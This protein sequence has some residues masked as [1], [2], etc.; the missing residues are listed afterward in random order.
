MTT[1]TRRLS[2]AR[3]L[4]IYHRAR[5]L[6]PGTTQLISR[7]PTRAALGF[8]PIYAQSARGCRIT[9]V[10]GNEFIDW[11][12]AVGP[13]ILGYAH[14][15][16]DAAVK[17][18]IDRG[19]V[20]S[21]V[22]E[23]SVELAELLVRLV[24]SAEMVRYAKGGGEACTIAVRIAR[25]VTGRDKVLLCGYHGWHD[26]YLAANLGAERLADHLFNGIDPIGVPRALEGTALPFE[27]GDLD[28]LED[29]LRAHG[30]DVA[31]IIMEPMRCEMPPAGYL[32]GVRALAD[33]YGVVLIFDEVS[34]GWRIALGGV[35]QVTGVTPDLT[36]F[37]KA[38]SNGYP[39]AAVA[40]RRAVMEPVERMFISSAYW[41]DNIGIAASLATIRE[42]ERI[43]APALFE[44]LGTDFRERIDGLARETGCPAQ[45]VGVAA[46]PRIHFDVPHEQAPK[47]A[48][49]F[50]QE[51]ARRGV[52]LASGFFFNAAHD[53]DADALDRTEAVVRESFAVIADGLRRDRLD[54]LIECEL[55]E[56]S[57]RRLVR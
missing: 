19:S 2:V 5:Q 56:E 38:M 31:A 28:R 29:L 13:I 22:H 16:V 39:M 51:N 57:F 49:L 43:D 47:V 41:D 8:S 37:A 36:V 32:E 15:V 11:S 33:R 23:S 54:D 17:A 48:T 34:C 52:I 12:S 18:Q 30:G 21:I 26:W 14:P 4:E 27:W 7:R 3:S 40:G 46:H 45:C 20:Y 53:A 9:D 10:D 25:G 44:R 50:V 55:V 35:Q 24:P 42:L 1:P 6:I